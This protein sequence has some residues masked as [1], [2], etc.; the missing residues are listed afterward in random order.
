MRYRYERKYF[1]NTH[2]AAVLRGRAAAVM[3][4]D[5]HSG[6]V[7]VVNNLYLD[8]M[9][10]SFYLDKQLGSIRREKYRVRHYNNDLSFIRL[11]RKVKNGLVSYKENARITAEQYEMIRKGEFAFAL[12]AGDPLLESLGALHNLRT[13]RPAAEFSYIREAYIYGPGNVRVTFDSQIGGDIPG[14]PPDNW[15]PPGPGGMVEVKYDGFLPS[16]ISDLLGGLPIVWTDMSKYCYVYERERGLW[17]YAGK[18]MGNYIKHHAG[19]ES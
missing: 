5:A 6:G 14:F 17:S 13:L 1:L 19:R 3:R 11:E 4:P 8:D 7:Y 16:V 12:E 2:T 10:G 15:T 9:Y 18:S